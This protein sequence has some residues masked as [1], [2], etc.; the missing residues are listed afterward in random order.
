MLRHLIL[1]FVTITFPIFCCA[2]DYQYSIRDG[3]FAIHNGPGYFN[4]PLFGTHELTMLL[5]GDRPAF[6]YF[7]PT[8][9]G[10]IGNLYLGLVTA[11]GGKWLHHFAEIESLYQPGLTRHVVQDP[12][13]PGGSLEVTAVPLSG[14]EGFT[15]RLRW[16]KPPSE[17]VRLVWTF[18]GASG[19]DR[20]Y[21]ARIDKLHLSE[22]DSERNLIHVWGSRFSLTSPTMKGKKILGTCDLPGRLETKNTKEVVTGPAEAELAAAS[23]TPVVVYSEDYIPSGG[24]LSSLKTPIVVFSGDWAQRND[25]VHL[26]FTMGGA[27]TLEELAGDP[28][29]TYTQSVNFYR[30]LATRVQVKTPDPY[31]NLAVESMVIANDGLWKPPAILHGAM[32][33]TY[34]YLGWRGLYG[35]Q[36][37]GWHD[38]VRSSIV[39]HAARQSQRGEN[40]GALP[41]ML[42]NPRMFIFNMNEVYLDHIYYHYLWTG[43]RSLMTSLLPVIR[44]ILLWEKRRLDP[45]DNAL[46]E[47]CLNTW[48][49][50]SHWYS[51]GDGTQ[52][53]AYMYRGHQL[54]AEAAEAAGEDPIPFQ[55][56]AVRI[57]KA[58]NDKLWIGS[59]GH[60]A[61]FIDRIGLKRMHIEPELATIYHP[62]EFGVTDQFQA[63]Q[64]LRFS[65]VNL[66]NETA[67]PNGGRLVWSSNWAPN[68][69]QNYTHSTYDLV[70]AENLNLAI[71]YYRA[72]QF[73]KAYELVKGVYAGMYMGGIPGG[74]SCSP[75][76]NGQQRA[77]EEFGDAIGMFARTAVEG[78]FGILPEMQRGL[79]HLSPGFPAAWKDAS[80]QTP[81]LAYHF[82]KTDSEIIVEVTTVRPVRIHYRVPVHEARVVEVLIDGSTADARVEPAIGG[83]FVDVT[84]PQANRSSVR[85]RFEPTQMTT[86]F[87]SIVVP[88]ENWTIRIEGA[89]L[90]ELKDPQR[91]L[92]QTSLREHSL[93]GTID[94]AL[95]HHTVFVLVGED[96]DSRW[97]PINIE[98]RAPLEIVNTPLDVRTGECHFVL[99]NNTAYEVKAEAK[100]QWTGRTSDM[101]IS[102]PSGAERQYK[103]DGSVSGLLLG[104]NSLEITGFA[105]ASRLFRD[106]LYWPEHAPA[107]QEQGWRPL[108][109][110]SFYNESLSTVLL[111]PFW[112][113]EYPYSVCCDYMLDHLIG[114]RSKLPNDRRLRASV[115]KQ[116]VF[117]TQVG[118]P[119]A[120]RAKGNNMVALSRWREFS[121]HIEIPVNDSTRKIYLL[122]SGVTFPM[123]SQIANA[124]V[125]VHYADGGESTMDLV[126]PENFDNGWGGFGGNYHY[127]ANGMEV[128]ADKPPQATNIEPPTA[129]P[130]TILGQHGMPDPNEGQKAP[131]LLGATEEAPHADIVDLDCDPTRRIRSVEVKVLSNEIILGLLGVTLLK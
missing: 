102:L 40:R 54:A 49:S 4:R 96:K 116:G 58:M 20:H 67:I 24:Q 35:P 115:S 53:S 125:V 104:K 100:A 80:I 32:C 62:I 121:D 33:W 21:S 52:A 3:G 111:H 27:E 112:T 123:Q 87:R 113:S 69:N 127:A 34:H 14:A 91:V 89:R 82:R 75:Y 109:L 25:S 47:N 29:E 48:I 126:N 90:R 76:R 9:L 16:I 45:D 88:G 1:L 70:F 18:G 30:N 66:R 12:I 2:A 28:S 122:I 117:V 131:Q 43:D 85:I 101:T 106:V 11:Q 19:Y 15:L 7:A 84:G 81:D 10:K 97:E 108:S 36:A 22:S 94:G 105:N 46:Y 95:G 55:Q 65:E 59:K 103:A 73:D 17:K 26:V 41:N 129:Q 42:E 86:H 5:S 8:D 38:R 83:S 118:I 128:I 51:G 98:V 78:V 114:A 79:I 71:A 56:E 13:F 31:F 64:M 110:D 74:L 61:E 92:S 77:H 119:F 120:Q 37:F 68:F 23:K 72:G 60:Y 99:R 57:R 124:R 63:Y 39:A 50:D 44:G 93:S 6:A 107:K 130:V